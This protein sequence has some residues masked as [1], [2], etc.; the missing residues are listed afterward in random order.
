M[1]G[2]ALPTKPARI[3]R[4]YAFVV[5]R[6][7]ASL[8]GGAETLLGA[9]ARHLKERGDTVCILTTCARDNR[10]WENSFPEGRTVEEGLEIF[11]YKVSERD[12]DAWIPRQIHISEGMQL[13]VDEELV[14]ME[15]GVNATGL[16]QHIAQHRDDYDALFFGPYLFATTFWGAQI[17]P[18]KSFLI[19]C[20]HDEHY[21]YTQV[22]TSL[23]RQ[24][25]GA[26]FNAGAEADLARALY[27]AIEGYEVGMGFVP[28]PQ[29]EI[30]TPF[31]AD[32]FPYI[33]Y[34]GRKET[35]KNVQVLI[36]YFIR[37]KD[38]GVI[39]ADTK[40]VIAGGGDFA[41]LHR[42]EARLRD[43]IIDQGHLSELDKRR[44]IKH[45]TALCQPSTNESFSIV[46]MEAWLEQ[47]PVI[48]HASC[49]V[50]RA[51]VVQAGGGLYFGSSADFGIVAHA[52]L[53]D[54]ALRQTLGRSGDRYVRE[55]YS[56]DAVL[57]RF[58]NAMNKFLSHD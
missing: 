26:L 27:G 36:D 50:T 53:E 32:P 18:E 45:A 58:D 2:I 13:G 8:A 9:L 56:W 24:V 34:V 17:A 38:E 3:A 49:P 14:W 22:I 30:L 11:R 29:H 52:L 31:F 40:L 4:R 7:Y 41:D 46:L 10:T 21:A 6:Y 20:L 47:V 37:A 15:H 39:R 54:E 43:D 35:G 1:E 57:D 48:V 51:H 19:P 55:H 28:P 16:Y 23:F 42:P 33:L 12:L 5:P 44:L 25:R